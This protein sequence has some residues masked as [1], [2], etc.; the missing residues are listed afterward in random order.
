MSS[1]YLKTEADTEKLAE[2]LAKNTKPPCVIF[3]EG[4]LGAG[5]TTFLRGFLKGLGCAER[6]KSPTFTL[7]ESYEIAAGVVVHMDLYRLKDP[8]ELEA[9]GFR[10]YVTDNAILV[11]EWAKNAEKLLPKPDILCT[12]KIPENGVGRMVELL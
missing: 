1:L 7:L 6:A 12:I 4:P 3:L 5:K 8:L 10:D 9:L 11:I 2:K